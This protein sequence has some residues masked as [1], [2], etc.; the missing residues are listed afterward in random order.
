MKIYSHAM[1]IYYHVVKIYSHVMRIVFLGTLEYFLIHIRLFCDASYSTI[2]CD[3]L[4]NVDV[5]FGDLEK[6]Y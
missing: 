2:I 3:F 1:K 5:T 4:I 6:N